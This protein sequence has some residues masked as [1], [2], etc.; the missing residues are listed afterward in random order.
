[1]AKPNTEM[2]D[3]DIKKIQEIVKQHYHDILSGSMVLGKLKKIIPILQRYAIA[4][5]DSQG[6]E[7]NKTNL[8]SEQQ[9]L[10]LLRDNGFPVIGTY[11]NVFEVQ[12]G[13]YG[14]IMDWIPNACLMDA[15]KPVELSYA[16]SGLLLGYKVDLGKEQTKNVNFFKASFYLELQKAELQK[17]I[18]RAEV[19][20]QQLET[21]LERFTEQNLFVGD[22]QVLVDI[23]GQCTIIDPHHLARAVPEPHKYVDALDDKKQ[24]PQDSEKLINNSIDMLGSCVKWLDGVTKAKSINDVSDHIMNSLDKGQEPALVASSKP[25]K[26]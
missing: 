15:K 26:R 23:N 13:Q 16:L 11:G 14:I 5:L 1:M 3:E 6:P 19:L 10:K 22:L 18:K 21:L 20:K 4:V 17:V 24:L 25:R 2:K 7:E 8:E 9:Y 12:P